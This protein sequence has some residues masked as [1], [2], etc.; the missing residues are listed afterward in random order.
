MLAIWQAFLQ[1]LLAGLGPCRRRVLRALE[2]QAPGDVLRRGESSTWSKLEEGSG[3]GHEAGEVGHHGVVVELGLSAAHATEM[4]A[5]S[6]SEGKGSNCT[7]ETPLSKSYATAGILNSCSWA[8]LSH[9]RH[10][11]DPLIP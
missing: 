3:R 5:G 10:V 9:V 1:G 7:V 6:F 11:P 4:P 8:S 2:T